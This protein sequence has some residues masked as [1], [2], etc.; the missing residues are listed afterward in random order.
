MRLVIRF[1]TFYVGG[2][3]YFSV[4]HRHCVLMIR[5]LVKHN[6]GGVKTKSSVKAFFLVLNGTARVL[7]HIL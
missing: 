5:L 1:E 3:I 6:N 2:E 7:D 4:E